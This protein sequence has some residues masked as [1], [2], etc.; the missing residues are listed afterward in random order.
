MKVKRNLQDYE[1]GADFSGYARVMRKRDFGRISFWKVRFQEEDYQLFIQRG[2]IENFQ[3]IKKLALG[4]IVFFEGKKMVT[5]TGEASILINLIQVEHEGCDILQNKLGGINYLGKSDSR[6]LDLIANKSF[7]DYSL[8]LSR[9][10]GGIRRFLSENEFMEFTTGILQECFEG[11]QAVPFQTRCKTN[12]KT[13]YLSLTSELKLKRLMIAGFE[14]VYEISQSFRNE[15]IDK[16]HLPEFTLLELYAINQSYKDMI[17]FLEKMVFEVLTE[18]TG[19]NYVKNGADLISFNPPFER[20]TFD[21]ACTMFLKIEGK[22][23]TIEWLEERFPGMFSRN[24]DEFT[25]TMK[26]V[27]KIFTPNFIK[28]TFLID[29]PSG[30]SPFAKRQS[31]NEK[32]SESAFFIAMGINIATISTDENNVERVSMFLAEQS[33]KTGHVVNQDYLD[34]LEFGLPQTAGIGFGLNRFFM[35]FQEGKK[36]ARETC[37]FPLF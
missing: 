9:L 1:D 36:S 13:F 27:D 32:I 16:M 17:N 6:V 14:K 22:K 37:L 12:G 30:I 7:F 4:S 35:I 34:V 2:M 33:K 5:K 10:L 26:L 19:E 25:W 18:A 20:I 3:E 29:V 11:G 28:P 23:C 21:E 24:M 8:L 31:K 15:G